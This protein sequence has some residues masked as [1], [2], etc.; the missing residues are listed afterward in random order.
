M[1]RERASRER[2]R[3]MVDRW[4]RSGLSAARFCRREGLQPRRLSYWRHVVGARSGPAA[5]RARLAPVQ[6]LDLG[7]G[8]TASIEVMLGG[9]DRLVV[10]ERVSP[11]LLRE[12]LTALRERC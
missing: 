3:R 11:E 5:R 9:G 7:L 6:V 10:R 12:V 4:E 8:A 1:A 2:M